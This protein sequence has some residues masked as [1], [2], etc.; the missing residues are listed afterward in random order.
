MSASSVLIKYKEILSLELERTV[1][2]WERFSL[3]YDNGGYFNNLDDQGNVFDRT[4]HVWLQCREVWMW[5]TLSKDAQDHGKAEIAK[6]FLGHAKLGASFIKRHCLWNDGQRCFFSLTED[7]KPIW[8]QRK[9]WAECFYVIACVVYG[10]VSG[11]ATFEVEGLRM[12]QHLLRYFKE[13]LLL[14]RPQLAGQR[15]MITLGVPMMLLNLIDEIRSGGGGP[16]GMGVSLT[17]Y[18]SEVEWCLQQLRLHIKPDRKMVF[19]NVTPDGELFL[20][21]SEGRAIN[22][23]HAIEAGWFVLQFAGKYFLDQ[24]VLKQEL[25]QTGLH[26]IE[27]SYSA[28]WDSAHG[29]IFYFLDSEGRS[30]LPLE[31]NMKLWWPHCEAMVAWLYAYKETKNPEH[32]A[33]FAEVAEYTL[34]TF[35]KTPKG[36]WYGYASRSGQLTHA[37]IGMPYKGFFHVPRAQLLCIRLLEQLLDESKRSKL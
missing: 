27:W 22:P 32:L 13:P 3:D 9:P 37:N 16:R 31:S 12:F 29:G 21:S 18:Q 20:D 17:L 11:D 23:G 1:P 2:F 19:E 24:S 28:G 6:R 8:S 33:K 4:K 26:M 34:R 14:G 25:V 35:S 30:A 15:G 36:G 5:A 7:G 10:R